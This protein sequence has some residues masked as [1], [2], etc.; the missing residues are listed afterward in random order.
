MKGLN[1]TPDLSDTEQQGCNGHFPSIQFRHW[2]SPCGAKF[3]IAVYARDG[4]RTL[5]LGT[6]RGTEAAHPSATIVLLAG[7]AVKVSTR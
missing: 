1:F 6:A 7:L 2:K 3:A 5:R 4:N